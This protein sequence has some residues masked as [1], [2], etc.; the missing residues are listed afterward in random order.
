MIFAKITPKMLEDRENFSETFQEKQE[1]QEDKW[2]S[3]FAKHGNGISIIKTR[4]M[5]TLLRSGIPNHLRGRLWMIC[6]G[7]YAHLITCE[8]NYYGNLL[9]NTEDKDSHVEDEIEKDLHRSLPEHEY[10]QSAEGI[11]ALRRVLTAYARH[12]PSIGYCQSMNIVTAVLLLFFNEEHAF[13]MLCILCEQLV[14]DYYVK[15]MIGSIVDQRILEGDEWNRM[16]LI[17]R[18]INY[19]VILPF[20]SPIPD[21]HYCILAGMK[22][23][24]ELMK[25]RMASIVAHLEEINL[26]IP[27]I[28]LPWFMCLFI[29][30]VPFEATLRILDCLFGLDG[31]HIL[32]SIALV[33]FKLNEEYI[34]SEED[35]GLIVQKIRESVHDCDNLLRV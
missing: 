4:K 16:E 21:I 35:S 20:P 6:S 31:T 32:F 28:T 1:K 25:Q 19:I 13:H 3:Y 11:D 14:P 9:E 29:G 27:L 5:K 15:A 10:F 2:N 23:Y 7:C 18:L 24:I 12:N 33:L 34:L 22:S 30:Y 26:P 17:D 8:R